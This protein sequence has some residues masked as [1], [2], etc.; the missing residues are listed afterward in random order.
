[1][2]DT[3]HCYYE[4]I[5]NGHEHESVIQIW[6]RTWQNFGWKTRVL[7]KADSMK[8]PLLIPFME[9]VRKLPTFNAPG[10]E[11]ACYRRHLAMEVVGG[12]F[13]T[14]YDVINHGFQPKDM[15]PV[16]DMIETLEP[17]GVPC[18]VFGTPTA[19]K[20]W[21]YH[22]GHYPHRP[23]QRHVSDMTIFNEMRPFGHGQ[24]LNLDYNNWESA[25]LIHFHHEGV[26]R[27]RPGVQR[28]RFIEDF[29]SEVPSQS[30]AA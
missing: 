9:H 5:G 25:P 8:H 11:A 6:K 26:K 27:L 28:H 4:Q 21:I 24:C 1:M 12:G 14:D 7:G 19:W 17:G 16:Q 10:Y 18:A 23:D 29:L 22:L 3:V 2:I 15:P 20:E 30:I 13:L